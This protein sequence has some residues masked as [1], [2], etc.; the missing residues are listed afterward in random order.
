MNDNSLR[1]LFLSTPVGALG[2]GL[3]GGVELTLHNIAQELLNRG[4]HL[5]ILAP[6]GSDL[7]SLP[8]AAIPGRLQL[9]AQTQGRDA[10]IT[11]PPDAV[12]ANLWEVARQWQPDYDLLLNFAYDWLP[13]YLTPFFDRPVAHLVSMG[14]LTNAMDQVIQQTLDRFPGTIAVHSHAQAATFG[15]GDRCVCLGNGLDLSL[16]SF[17]PQPQNTLGW[18]GRIA[19]EKGIEDAIAAAQQADIPLKIWGAMPDPNY[20]QAVCNAYPNAQFSYEGFLSTSQL[21]AELGQ[22]RA[23]LMTPKWVEAFGN[24]A[25]EALACGVPVI[26]YRRGGPSEI[27]SQGETGWLVEP[28]SVS[29]LVKA[30]AQIEKI[31]RQTCRQQVEAIYSMQ[32]MGDRVEGWLRQTLKSAAE[33]S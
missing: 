21:Q 13:F 10:P 4:H 26:A 25:I 11:L 17:Q 15:F 32:A 27:V 16:Y 8:I 6:A 31:D 28:D 7:G 9:T 33:T 2:S 23:L 3:G 22:C 30:I 14:S 12:L 5:K 18:I 20:W 19:P 1:L 29:G 24:V